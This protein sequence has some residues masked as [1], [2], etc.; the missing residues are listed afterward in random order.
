MFVPTCVLKNDI[1]EANINQVIIGRSKNNHGKVID[2]LID[3][4]KGKENVE[5]GIIIRGLDSV[6]KKRYGTIE[7]AKIKYIIGKTQECVDLSDIPRII[8]EDIVGDTIFSFFKNMY[9]SKEEVIRLSESGVIIGGHGKNHIKLSTRFH[10]KRKID[11]ELETAYI[12]LKT[13]YRNMD[14]PI[15]LSFLMVLMMITRKKRLKK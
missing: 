11:E 14:V 1:L 5:A 15:M 13:L 2:K 6:I 12:W 8:F 3:L 4:L 10:S 9:I 7:E